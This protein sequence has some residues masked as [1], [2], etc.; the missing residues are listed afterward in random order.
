MPYDPSDVVGYPSPPESSYQNISGIVSIVVEALMVFANIFPILVVCKWKRPR[1]RMSTDE[2]IVALSITDILSVV[3]P[4]PLGLISYFSRRWYGGYRTCAFY[5]LTT[6]WFQLTSVFLVTY[7][8]VDRFLVVRAATQ[9]KIQI[10]SNPKVKIVVFAI[11]F[12]TLIISCLPLSGLAPEALSKSGKLCQSWI[13]AIPKK[14][15]EHVFYISFI[16]LG[17]LNLLTVICVNSRV[18]YVL[19]A[20]MKK[21]DQEGKL[22]GKTLGLAVDKKA[23]V[24]CSKMVV[25][26]TV[27]SYLA[28]LPALVGITFLR[29]FVHN[30]ICHNGV[31]RS[32]F[33]LSSSVKAQANHKGP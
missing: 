9:Q 11:Y 32:I 31:P 20:F 33:A 16:S 18:V 28:W 1:E 5:Q 21:L 17:F 10:Q 14:L 23:V 7:M 13:I 25:M 2:I 3:V 12:F 29:Q 8:C 15:K 6:S 4:S 24:D 22:E 26:I 27:V 19:K 30:S